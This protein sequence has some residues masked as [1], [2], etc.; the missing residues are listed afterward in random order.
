MKRYISILSA[1]LS[2]ALLAPS[3]RQEV[4]EGGEHITQTAMLYNVDGESWTRANAYRANS[5]NLSAGD[6][7]NMLEASFALGLVRPAESDTKLTLRLDSEVAKQYLR[8]QNATMELFPEALVDLPKVVEIAKGS[9]M[10]DENKFKIYISEAIKEGV[11]YIFAISLDTATPSNPDDCIRLSDVNHS[12]IY[13]LKVATQGQVEI[14]KVLQLERED[15]IKFEKHPFTNFNNYSNFTIE[16]LVSIDKFRNSSSDAG[17]AGIST[18]FGMEGSMLFRFGDASVEPNYLQAYGQRVNFDF[19]T[20][21]WYHLAF[22]FSNGNMIVYVDGKEQVSI[23][24]KR[25]MITTSGSNAFFIGRSWSDN[26]GI[27]AKFAE[28]R[29]WEV[30]RTADELTESMYSVDPKSDGLLTYW[31]M[32]SAEGNK[33]KNLAKL[34]NADLVHQTQSGRSKNVSITTLDKPIDIELD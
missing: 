23:P 26:R 32:D 30:A 22:V 21:R 25:A 18:L 24:G 33:I 6:Q 4:V 28:M 12:L 34:P 3:C 19:Q 16:T 1:I 2:F 8:S 14:N 10:S 11:T 7:V 27:Q 17:E 20:K 29:I 13:T 31:K 5:I 15:Y 9:M